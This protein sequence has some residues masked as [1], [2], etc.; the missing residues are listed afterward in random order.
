LDVHINVGHDLPADGAGGQG[1][2]NAAEVL[3]LSPVLAEKYM[4]AAKQALE[5]AMRD[6]RSRQRIGIVEPGPGVAPSQAAQNILAGFLPR[7]FRRPVAAAE[8]EP[9]LSLFRRA[10]TEHLTFD[11]SVAYMLRGV[12]MSPQFIFRVAPLN[13]GSSPRLVNDYELASRLSYFLW[14]SMPDEMLF[15][16]ASMGKLH[17]PAVLKEEIGRMLRS[18]KAMEFI[19][20]FVTQWLGT[21]ELGKEFI[22]DPK[23]FPNYSADADL[24]GDI[25]FQPIVFFHSMITTDAPVTDL[26]DSNWTIITKKLAALYGLD[27]SVLRK[28]NQEQPHRIVL[29][30][31]SDR[32]R[33][34]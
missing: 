6:S 18:G 23:L 33:L 15:D 1:F 27:K 25:R 26:L 3:F 31:D 9:F 24:Q 22:P 32:G 34:H 21:R 2:D 11:S 4:D 16:L 19:E 30:A 29:P 8:M 14:G 28:E 17:E 12:L 7:S 13:S 10:Q 5:F 20:S